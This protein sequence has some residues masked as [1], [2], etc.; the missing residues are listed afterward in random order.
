MQ[1]AQI[2]CIE[3]LRRVG[4]GFPI[5][6][7]THIVINPIGRK[8]NPHP[9]GRENCDYGCHNFAQKPIAIFQAAT[10]AIGAVVGFGLQELINQIAIGR[11]NFHPIKTRRLG[12]FGGPAI[13]FH[14]CRHLVGFQGARGFVGV[15]ARGG[16]DVVVADGDRGGRNRQRLIGAETA[17]G[18]AATVPQLQENFA[19]PIVHCLGDLFPGFRLSIVVNAGR[20][21]PTNALFRNDGGFANQKASTRS[22]G[23]IFRH[24]GIGQA[25]H[26]CTGAG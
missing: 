9:I 18:S 13:V 11:V 5:I 15:F 4:K 23:I 25:L 19:V 21:L 20:V 7:R 22:L 10:V 1:I 6:R 2:Q 8:P 26:P 17:V 24:Q 3:L 14:H 12:S 16:V